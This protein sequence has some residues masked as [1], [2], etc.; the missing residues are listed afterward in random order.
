MTII[1]PGGEKRV[2]LTYDGFASQSS[3]AGNIATELGLHRTDMDTIDIHQY[4]GI[5]R[6]SAQTVRAG[7][8]ELGG[9]QIEFMVNDSAEQIL[10]ICEAHIPTAWQRK[11]KMGS[12]KYNSFGGIN[13]ITIGKDNANIFPDMLMLEGKWC[14]KSH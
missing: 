5:V 4:N 13:S 11:Y 1:A 3:I 2:L 9:K 10:P 14:F 7:L 6:S 12:P 8:K